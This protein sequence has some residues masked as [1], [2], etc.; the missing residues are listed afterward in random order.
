[1]T[2]SVRHTKLA[3]VLASVIAAGFPCAAL[4]GFEW[5][6]P[7]ASARDQ[8][9]GN[10]QAAPDAMTPVPG[11]PADG[12]QPMPAPLPEVQGQP[13]P[14]VAA[15]R[16]PVA[17]APPPSP[18]PEAAPRIN[19]FPLEAAPVAAPAP[20]PPPSGFTQAVGFGEQMPLALAMRQIVP[21]EYGFS[22]A[23]GVNPGVKIDWEGGRP[24]N[25]VLGDAIAPYGL[26]AV[27]AGKAVSIRPADRPATGDAVALAP[28]PGPMTL[29]RPA[30]VAMPEEAMPPVAPAMPA[31]VS[32]PMM[33]APM[34]E[35]LPPAQE[36][37]EARLDEGAPVSGRYNPRADRRLEEMMPPPVTQGLANAAPEQV[38]AMPEPAPMPPEDGA[39]AAAQPRGPE[40]AFPGEMPGNIP[41]E[42]PREVA[43]P[44]GLGDEMARDPRPLLKKSPAGPDRKYDP[45]AVRTW[46]AENGISLR[47]A[48]SE[49]SDEAG[50]QLHWASQYDYP[51]QSAVRLDGTY[52]QAVDMVLSGLADAQPRPLGRLHPNMPEGPAILVIETRHIIE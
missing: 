32:A 50:V 21:P 36:V 46:T 38:A 37:P 8:A 39:M 52:S 47:E 4:A 22:F 26:T 11:E 30:P 23:D 40:A 43:P 7:P 12:F 13:L 45:S 1:M 10:T 20:V 19:P 28:P 24:W 6:P 25:A 17:V 29:T 2:R 16:A 48:L 35:S 31:P 5:S 34:P 18:A 9:A 33:T 42:M 14:G 3:M 27:V 44:A 15:P 41:G 51:L 49:W